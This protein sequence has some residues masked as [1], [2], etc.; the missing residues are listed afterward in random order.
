SNPGITKQLE[1][2]EKIL[3]V[4]FLI[5]AGKHWVG[6]DDPKSYLVSP[7][8]GDL[9]G[10]PP[11]TIFTGT[12]DLLFP[13]A[14]KLHE[15]LKSMGGRSEL[16]VYDKMLHDFAIFPIPEAKRATDEIIEKVRYKRF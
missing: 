9:E 11:I 12:Y 16:K 8:N 4:V 2:R 14:Q 1:K 6:E 5:K 15:K 3:T 7:I 10:L 13:D